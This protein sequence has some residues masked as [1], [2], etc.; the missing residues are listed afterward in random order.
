MRPLFAPALF[1]AC[2]Q[3][4]ACVSEAVTG[5]TRVELTAAGDLYVSVTLPNLLVGTVGGGTSLPTARECL[6]MM[7]CYGDGKARKLAEIFA[8]V[9]L[10]GELALTGAMASGSFAESHGGTRGA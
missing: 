2:G 3:D 7:G 1:L 4:V 5:L 8:A 6:E 9:A 10:T